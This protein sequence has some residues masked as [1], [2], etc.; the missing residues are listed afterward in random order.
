MSANNLGQGQSHAQGDSVVP[1]PVQ[2]AAPKGLEEALP[3]K[4]S[5]SLHLNAILQLSGMIEMRTSI[6]SV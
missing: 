1:K 5:Q 3:D 2:D 4:V 6:D